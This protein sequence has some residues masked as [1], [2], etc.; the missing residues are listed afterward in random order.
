M[1]TRLRNWSVLIRLPRNWRLAI[2]ASLWRDLPARR[3]VSDIVAEVIRTRSDAI[4]KNVADNNAL[5]KALSR[6]QK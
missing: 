4:A 3:S 6:K 1:S 5:F 2:G